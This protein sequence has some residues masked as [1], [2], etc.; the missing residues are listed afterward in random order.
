MAGR[1]V[2]LIRIFEK[3][4]RR[5][6]LKSTLSGTMKLGQFLD[7]E[8]MALLGNFFGLAPLR[9]NRKEEVRLYFDIL[10]KNG[11]E[12][13][14]LEKIGDYLG[15]SLKPFSQ[16]DATEPARKMF[17]RLSLAYPILGSLISF[18]KEDYT[19]FERMF[20]RNSE[21]AVNTRCFQTGA[22]V[23][24]LLENS[25]PITISELGAR[26]CND[27]KALRQGE[28]RNL[29]V[30]WLRLCRPDSDMLERE[31]DLWAGYNVLS[32]QLTVNAVLYGP[33]L[34]E[35]K[36]KFFDWIYQLYKQGESATISW[37]NIHDIDRI[38]WKKQEEKVPV[39]V[40]CENEAPFSN[41]MRRDLNQ[42]LLFTSG[43]PGSA[44]QKLYQ[45]LAPQAAA[46]YHWGDSDP[47]GLHIAAIMHSLFPLQ[48]YRCDLTNLQSH[49]HCLLP[50]SQ[51]QR[52]GAM[53]LLVNQPDFP[54]GKELLFTLEN[55]WLEQESWQS[56]KRLV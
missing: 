55:G 13:Q 53:H 10:F 24:F 51:K 52:D 7:R 32:D 2:F 37:S 4:A 54:F 48:L 9:V 56:N 17:S 27:S 43:F 3:I 40:S 30:Q 8:E 6:Q 29:V 31:E 18:L 41:L 36:G 26:F 45:L 46:C 20:A 28:L 19:P 49:K 44:V 38:Y 5:Y 47:A 42:A 39:L 16:M 22:T 21:D 11:L 34:Y 15:Y 1:E 25:E 23:S 14:W 33:V 35:K 50:L 12:E